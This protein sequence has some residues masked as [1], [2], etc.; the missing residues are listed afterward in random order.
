MAAPATQGLA[1]RQFL[2]HVTSGLAGLAIG[3]VAGG[4]AGPAALRAG[5][6]VVDITPP[7]GIELG[8]F[9]RRPGNERRVRA[10]RQRTVARALVLQQGENR[11]AIC[12]LEV[13]CVGRQL[14]DG[15]RAQVAQKAG[16]PAEHVRVTCTHTHSM[17][18]FCFARQWGAIP[19]QYMATVQQRAVEAVCRAQED[20]APAELLVGTSRAVGGNHNRTARTWL[21]DEKFGPDATDATRWLDTTVH[22]LLF[23]RAGKPA[24]CWYHFSAHAVC[25]ADEQAGPDWP[26][27]VAERVRQNE[28]LDPGLLQGHCGDVNPGDGKDWRGEIRQSVAAIYPAVKEAI[29]KAAAVACVPLRSL[30]EEFRLPYDLDRFRSWL[31][32]YRGDPK[33]CAS[34]EWVDA[35]FAEDWYRGNAGRD[36]KQTHLPISLSALRL[37]DL[38]MLFH[39]AELYSFYGLAIR[40]DSPFRHTLVVGYTDDMVGYLPD[41][42]AYEAGEYAALTVPK[43]L[44]YPPFAP[45]AARQMTAAAVKLLARLR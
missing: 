34:G 40:R 31:E 10:I 22:A 17:P 20:L 19:E 16:I 26:G 43:I 4:A 18:A 29:A 39:P 37:G 11:A 6:A 45:T 41:P 9:H 14:A 2:A 7:L 44:D 42:K 25:Y 15:I 33:A 36:L 21:S 8:G 23:P 5:E 3:S 27:E 28:K 32:R 13:A 24:L 35:G 1:R 30:R 38:A 12:S